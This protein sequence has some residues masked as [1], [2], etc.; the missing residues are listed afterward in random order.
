MASTSRA[1]V[2]SSVPVHAEIYADNSSETDASAKGAQTAL[3][4]GRRAKGKRL[5][6][7]LTELRGQ[8][9]GALRAADASD[10]ALCI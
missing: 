1:D 4:P 5:G 9:E 2:D 3:C 8:L 7:A 6:V 10:S